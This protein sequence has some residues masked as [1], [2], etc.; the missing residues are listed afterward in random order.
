MKLVL[1]IEFTD[2]ARAA[3][4]DIDV[5]LSPVFGTI[6]PVTGDLVR[7]PGQPL[8]FIVAS[9]LWH[10]KDRDNV[11]LR[12]ILDLHSHQTLSLA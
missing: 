9:R 2:I 4:K 3:S 7:F 1:A 11:E 8:L 10:A 6:T 12:V 5:S